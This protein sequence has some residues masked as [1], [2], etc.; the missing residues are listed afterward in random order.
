MARPAVPIIMNSVMNA[1]AP[2]MYREDCVS[3]TSVAPILNSG[4]PIL[5]SWN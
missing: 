4:C 2:I 1:T 5:T 3:T